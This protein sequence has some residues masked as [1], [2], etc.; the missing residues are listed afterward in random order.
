MNKIILSLFLLIS[1]SICWAQDGVYLKGLNQKVK[2][3]TKVLRSADKS[4]ITGFREEF[5]EQGRK[6]KLCFLNKDLSV[7]RCNV[8]NYD[9]LGAL[10]SDTTYLTT[11]IIN[12]ITSYTYDK[13]SNLIHQNLNLIGSGQVIDYYFLNEFDDRGNLILKTSIDA[14]SSVNWIEKYTYN[15][16][17]QVLDYEYSYSDEPYQR[18]FKTY[19]DGKVSTLKILYFSDNRKFDQGENIE[20]EYN[21]SGKLMKEIYQT[22]PNGDRREERFSYSG[23]EI[24]SS[25]SYK[26]GVVSMITTYSYEYWE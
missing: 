3:K 13:D 26:Y 17:N 22:I 21:A 5:D 19:K 10:I 4:I 23:S 9:S 18:T 2:T 24:I 8:Y 1:Q 11:T 14:D 12:K 15:K 6:T 7:Q 16:D 25:T 20:F